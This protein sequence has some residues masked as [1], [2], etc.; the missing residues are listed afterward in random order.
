MINNVYTNPYICHLQKHAFA[1]VASLVMP[2]LLPKGSLLYEEGANFIDAEHR[3][4]MLEDSPDKFI[5]VLHEG[6]HMNAEDFLLQDIFL[7]LKCPY[8]DENVIGVHYKIPL[9][10]ALQL[11]CHMKAK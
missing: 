10:Y 6:E 4:F 11:L 9:Y 7:E 2:A 5:S 1:T 3:K 8:P